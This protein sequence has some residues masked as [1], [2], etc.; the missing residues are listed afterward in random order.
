MIAGQRVLD[1]GAG[2]GIVAVAAMRAGAAAALAVDVDPDAIALVALNAEANAVAVATLCADILDQPPPAVDW[3]L[4][5]DLFYE[6]ALARR[7]A[8][9]LD[10]CRAAGAEALIGDPGR[11]HL[12]LARLERL[13]EYRLADFGD[14]PAA[15]ATAGAVFAFRREAGRWPT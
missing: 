11:A 7:V 3:V 4:V 9:F 15:A 2:G 14:P 5:G 6:A 10:R 12:P 13:A 8:A 1:L